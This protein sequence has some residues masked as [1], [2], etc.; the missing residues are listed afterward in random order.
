MRLRRSREGGRTISGP[1]LAHTALLGVVVDVSGSMRESANADGKEQDSRIRMLHDSFRAMLTGT[2]SDQ[3]RDYQRESST[4]VEVFVLVFGLRH[5]GGGGRVSSVFHNAVDQSVQGRVKRMF[6]HSVLDGMSAGWREA[7]GGPAAP[8]VCDILSL[9]RVLSGASAGRGRAPANAIAPV[10]AA[11]FVRDPAV[12]DLRRLAAAHGIEGWER[13]VTAYLTQPGQ[14]ANVVRRLQRDPD[15]AA[16]LARLTPNLAP[17]EF[18]FVLDQLKSGN[19]VATARELQKNAGSLLTSAGAQLG[20]L[21]DHVTHV[22]LIRD[23]LLRL[24]APGHVDTEEIL[25]DLRCSAVALL[26]DAL[27]ELGDTTLPLD[28]ALRLAMG[29]GQGAGGQIEGF[30]YGGTPMRQ[31]LGA[32]ADRFRRELADAAHGTRAMLLLIT[33]GLSTDGDPGFGFE[34][35]D[36]LGLTTVICY[37]TDDDLE[38]GLTLHGK[39]RDSWSTAARTLFESASQVRP[40]QPLALALEEAG[41]T[42]EPGARYFLQGNHPDLVTRLVEAAAR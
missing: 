36:G 30:V 15:L 21:S 14:V 38:Q 29:A 37:L 27:A 8:V 5:G 10:V 3:A 40:G 16:A 20:R 35:L 32:A 22:G 25:A 1:A 13:A 7:R 33:D 17:E 18:E 34:R 12:E 9:L 31:A 2:W 4:T 11:S 41:W 26:F 28:E 42:I 39:A 23:A 24:A 19:P 6:A